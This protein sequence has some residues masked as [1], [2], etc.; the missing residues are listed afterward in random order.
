MQ[1]ASTRTET[2]R[3]V[4]QDSRGRAGA[5]SDLVQHLASAPHQHRK[6]TDATE[7]K[8]TGRTVQV[9]PGTPDLLLRLVCEGVDAPVSWDAFEFVGAPLLERES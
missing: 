4:T 9:I 7:A 2:N 1:G 6:Q 3:V 8:Y 5:F